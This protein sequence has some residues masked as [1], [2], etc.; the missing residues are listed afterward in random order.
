MTLS[1]FSFWCASPSRLHYRTFEEAFSKS[2]T[3]LNDELI[4]RGQLFVGSSQHQT[5]TRHRN[6]SALGRVLAHG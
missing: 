6:Y 1:F 5:K 4:N 2:D 3:Y